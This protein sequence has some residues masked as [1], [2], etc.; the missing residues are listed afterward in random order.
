[1]NDTLLRQWAML[2][3]IPRHPRKIDVA[4][5]E[6]KLSV[7]GYFISKRSIQRDLITLSQVVPLIADE[8]KPQGWS[9]KVDAA[10]LELPTLEPQAALTFQLVE[11]YMQSLLPSSTLAYLQP[12]FKTA[13]AVL[14]QQDTSITS[15]PDK[16]R[17]LPRGVQLQAPVIDQSVQEVIY[18]SLAQDKRTQIAYLA[19]SNT[20]TKEYSISPLALVVRDQVIYVLCTMKD[21]SD[22][23]QLALHRIKSAEMIEQKINRPKSFDV[24][25]YIASGAF[26]F[27]ENDKNIKLVANFNANA[28]AHLIETPISA[29]QKIE[30]QENGAFRLLATVPDT[31]EICWW[32]LA[33]GDQ[34]EVI[35][36]VKLRIKM[37]DI[38]YSMHKIYL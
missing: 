5:L 6:S 17:V 32:L 30:P 36:P 31:L 21:Y 23:R 3:Y 18:Q 1:M 9:W 28:I 15:W 24:D 14:N 27:L 34:I 37:R 25:T 20:E 38:V 4:T 19:R 12:W 29:D 16:I 2:N 8:A 10:Q 33:F 26:G 22:I 11:R 7:A 13:K 35:S